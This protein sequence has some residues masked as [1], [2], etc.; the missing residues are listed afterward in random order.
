MEKLGGNLVI[1]SHGKVME[2]DQKNKVM[3]IENIL[4]KSW[5]FSTADHES[6]TRSSDNSIS[7]GLLSTVIWL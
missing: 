4:K 1:E 6:R 5:N 2:M 7:M 3:E